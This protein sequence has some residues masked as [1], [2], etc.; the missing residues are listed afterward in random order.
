MPRP[1]WSRPLPR[2]P[3]ATLRISR[4]QP[5]IAL[6]GG[7]LVASVR[8]HRTMLRAA[9]GTHAGPLRHPLG[10]NAS[11]ARPFDGSR[12]TFSRITSRAASPPTS[13]SCRGY[14]VQNKSPAITRG[15]DGYR[16]SSGGWGQGLPSQ[17]QHLMWC[18]CSRWRNS[19]SAELSRHPS[20]LAPH[21]ASPGPH[22][23]G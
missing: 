17:S 12:R 13:P 5:T 18:C 8:D 2:L 22:R 3:F 6:D 16:G 7:P 11:K 23:Y 20:A 4:E 21:S 1:D 14:W 15:A 19:A 9:G 10:I